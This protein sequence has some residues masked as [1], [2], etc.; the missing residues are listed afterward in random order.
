M[1]ERIVIVAILLFAGYNLYRLYNRW[2]LR[3][4]KAAVHVD[5]LLAVLRPGATAVVYFTTPGCVPCRTQQKPTLTRL[6]DE[7][8][9]KLQV[10]QIDAVDQPETAERWGVMSV[11]TTFVISSDG[12]PVAVNHGTAD[13]ITLRRQIDSARAS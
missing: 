5:P 2:H 4:A 6:Q 10:I 13:I 11:P 7:L 12:R 8:G 9:E 3:R 1:L